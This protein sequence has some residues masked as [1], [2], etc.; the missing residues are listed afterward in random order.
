MRKTK[1]GL[2]LL[3]ALLALLL[4]LGMLPFSALASPAEITVYVSAEN[5]TYPDGAWNGSLLDSYAVTVPVGTDMMAATIQALEENDITHSGAA[6]GYISEINGL[7]EGEGSGLGGWMSVL[8]DWFMNTSA[9]LVFPEDGD[10][11]R[12]MYSLDIGEDIGGS[13]FNNDT[14]LT[15]LTFSAG[16]LTPT[17]NEDIYD[18][19]LT[20]PAGTESVK[21]V[22][23]AANKN[24]Q[25]R[26]IVGGTEY[27][28]PKDVPTADGT[29]ITVR[30]GDPSWPTMN[31][32]SPFD[33]TDYTITVAID[34]GTT[35]PITG[36]PLLTG[37]TITNISGDIGFDPE[38]FS[39]DLTTSAATTAS[40]V[41]TP[42]FSDAYGLTVSDAEYQSGDAITVSTDIGANTVTLR[43]ADKLDEASYS[44]YTFNIFR[45]RAITL[46][47]AFT[48]LP[49][50]A[51]ALANI[52]IE[53][54]AECTRL[55]ASADGVPTTSTTFS[56][57]V[58]NYYAYLLTETDCIEI[59]FGNASTAGYIRVLA[60]GDEIYAPQP[61][62]N[63]MQL[64]DIPVVGEGLTRI[65][66]Q[67]CTAA[68][69]EDNGTGFIAEAEYT[70]FINNISLPDDDFEKMMLTDMTI[71]SGEFTTPFTPD[72]YIYSPI[73]IL[74]TY[75][76]AITYTFMVNDSETK[77]FR[78][79]TSSSASNTLTPDEEGFY[80][81]SSTIS[82]AFLP[83]QILGYQVVFATERVINGL[84]V[85]VQ[86]KIMYM[87]A[88]SLA[89]FK[90]V[91]Y[92]VP[93]SQYTN[94]GLYGMRPE[95][96][97]TGS[98]IS[99]GNF[100]GYITVYFEEAIKNDPANRYG[101]DLYIA[102]N[103]EDGGAGFAEPGNVWVSEDGEQW[104]LLAGS[105]YF[106]DNTLRDYEVT[107]SRLPNGGS[108]YTDNYGSHIVMNPDPVG[109][110]SPMYKYPL[111]A[112]YS[113]YKWEPG[114]ENN[115]TFTGPLLLGSGADPFG[116]TLAG[117]PFWG[118]VDVASSADNPYT[119]RGDGFDISWAIDEDGVPVYL[120]E[121]HYVKI[122]TASHIYSGGIGEKSTE[123]GEVRRAE[124][125]GN[126]VGVTAA[127]G[128]I[129]INGKALDV[130]DG[131]YIYSA[132]AGEGE[133]TISVDAGSANVFINNQGGTSRTYDTAPTSGIIR[134]IVQ[135]GEKEP[136]I[137]YITLAGL[138]AEPGAPW[139][140]TIDTGWY[141]TTAASFTI[142]TAGQLAGL[143][144]IVNGTAFGIDQDSFSEKAIIL[145]A[146]V[147]LSG[148]IEWTPIGSASANAFAGTFEGDG[149]TISGL[150]IPG[151]AYK[152][153]FGYIGA[154]GT[155]Y[156]LTISGSTIIGTEFIGLA[157]ARNEGGISG[158]T[159]RDSSV[160]SIGTNVGIVGGIVGSN[161]GTVLACANISADVNFTQSSGTDR[162]VGGIVGDNQGGISYCF[163]N[164]HIANI[165]TS[166]S[167]GYYGGI[168]GDN[169]GEIDSCYNTGV[170]DRGWYSGGIAGRSTVPIFNAYNIGDI[171][172]GGT[173]LGAIL[174]GGTGGSAEN[175]YCLLSA[176]ENSAK[177]GIAK[178]EIELQNIASALGGAFEDDL[179]TPAPINNGYPI[180]KWQDPEVTYTVTLTVTPQNA[181]VVFTPEGGGEVI[182]PASSTGG[183]FVFSGLSQGNYLYTVSNESEDYVQSGGSVSV[184]RVDINRVISLE[185]NLYQVEFNITPLDATVF[186]MTPGFE[187]SQRA[188]SGEAGF[189]LPMGTYGYRVSK[190]GYSDATGTVTVAKGSGVAAPVTAALEESAKQTVTFVVTPVGAVVTV[191]HPEDGVQTAGLDGTYELYETT[192]DYTVKL[193]GYI[194]EKG[195]FAVLSSGDNTVYVD[196]TAGTPV[197]NGGVAYGFYGGSGTEDDPYLIAEAEELAYM[198]SLFSDP[199]VYPDYSN[200]NY[201]L[202][203]EI[204]L[205]GAIEWA[206][207]GSSS[208]NGFAGIFDGHGHTINGLY[209]P[210]GTYK[211]L[212][213][214]V[215]AEG[216]VRNLTVSGSSVTGIEYVGLIA[217]S[218]AGIVSGITAEDSIVS[219][220][221]ANVGMIGGIVGENSGTIIAC[222][223]ISARVNYTQS[224]GTD[225]GVGGI[226]GG[227]S[228]EISLSINNARIANIGT[229]TSYGYY[230]GITGD[231]AGLIDSCYNTGVIDRG[232]NIGG[233]AGRSSYQ[234]LNSY[235]IGDIETG[236]T[237]G[238]I[239]AS[240][241]GGSGAT[242]VNCYCLDS[243]TTSSTNGTAKTETEIKGLAPELGGAFES[244]MTPNINNGYPIL[245]WQNPDTTYTVT[246]TVTP[247]D[248]EVVFKAAGDSTAL[249]P[250][251][252]EYGVYIFSG[253]SEGSYQY[254]VSND[255]GDYMAASGSISVSRADVSQAISLAKTLY[256]IQFNVT[257]AGTSVTV[258]ANGF[259]EKKTSDGT[260]PVVFSLPMGDYSYTAQK[261]G[262]SDVQ[263]SISVVKGSGV[264]APVTIAL[265]QSAQH[266]ITFAVTPG[267]A[268][269]SVI[270]PD[271]GIQTPEADG[272]YLLYETNYSYIVKLSGYITRKGTV[273][274]TG[275]ETIEIALTEGTP[276][277]DGAIA[278]SFYGGSGTELDPYL[279]ADGEELALLSGLI[280]DTATNPEYSTAYYKVVAH[281]DLGGNA[282]NFS[283]IGSNN[284]DDL[285]FEGSFDG[286]G[287]IISNLYV[288]KT[289]QAV[290]FFGFA[291]NYTGS[292][293]APT[294]G[295][296]KNVVL[297]DPVIES[298]ALYTGG[299][300]GWCVGQ[301]GN[302]YPITNCAVINGKVTSTS[303]Y[304]GGLVGSAS[305]PAI[306]ECYAIAEISGGTSGG[307][308]GVLAGAVVTSASIGYSFARGK[309]S[310]NAYV[311]GFIGSTIPSTLSIRYSYVD[312]EVVCTGTGT[313]ATYGLVSAASIPA[314]SVTN[315]Y[316]NQ[317]ASCTSSSTGAAVTSH[318]FTG[319]TAVDLK[320]EDTLVTLNA[321]GVKYALATQ[322]QYAND[323]YPYLIDTFTI[324]NDLEQLAAPTN[325][326]WS[327]FGVAEWDAVTNALGYKITL[328][329]SGAMVVTL[330]TDGSTHSL[331]LSGE[332]SMNGSGEYTFTVTAIG[333]GY[334][335]YN[336]PE[337]IL[338][339][340]YTATI[341]V[342]YVTFNISLPDGE[343]FYRPGDPVITV[344]VGTA[345]VSFVNGTAQTLPEGTGYLYE[346]RALGFSTI[347][348]TLNV[349]SSPV[350]VTET[351]A[352]DAGWDGVTTMEPALVDG[353]RLISSGY[354]L[355]WFRDE[356]NK[357]G[358]GYALNAKVVRDIDLAG[359]EWAP[360]STFTSSSATVGYTGT[361]DGNGYTISGL[362]ITT[363]ANGSGL[364][365]YV[366][367]GGLI[368]NVTVDGDTTGGQYSGGVAGCISAATISNCNN[369]A[370]VTYEK[371]TN[372]GIFVGGIVG[373]MSNYTYV[374]SLVE[375]C[376]NHGTITATTGTNNY[377]GGVVG[378]AS[379][380]VAIRYCG[381]E[382][383]VNGYTSIGGITGD[384]SIPIISCYNTGDVTGSSERVGGIAGFSNKLTQ[385]CYNIGAV[386]GQSQVGGIV[387]NLNNYSSPSGFVE[388]CY[389]VGSVTATGGIAATCGSI[390]GEKYQAGVVVANSF[391]LTGTAASGIGNNIHVDDSAVEMTET[392]LKQ[393]STVAWLGSAFAHV[394]GG[395]P[396]LRRQ[397]ASTD[398]AILFV[399][400]PS[401]A[402][403]VV[404]D[405]DD[406]IVYPAE[407]GYCYLLPTG[408]YKYEASKDDYIPVSGSITIPSVNT[409]VS[410]TMFPMTD[411]DLDITAAKAVI[412]SALSGVTFAQQDVNDIVG[413]KA[414]V[415]TI[416]AE[417]DLNGVTAIVADVAF[418]SAVAGTASN[419]GG[420]DGSYEF[421]VALTKGTG[422]EQIYSGSPTIAATPYAPVG[423]VT[424]DIYYGNANKSGFPVILPGYSLDPGL[425]EAFGFTDAYDGEQATMLDAV[426][427]AHIAVYGENFAALDVLRVPSGGMT[428]MFGD[429][430]GNYMF[431]VNDWIP[432]DGSDMYSVPQMTLNEGDDV[433]LFVGVEDWLGWDSYVW[434]ESGGSKAGEISVTTDEAVVLTLMGYDNYYWGMM[435]DYPDNV[436]IPFKD[437][438]IVDMLVSDNDA[439]LSAAFNGAAV[440][441][442]TNNSGV[443]TVT[444]DTPGVYYLS[445][446][447][448]DIEDDVPILP[449]WIVVTVTDSGTPPPLTD[450]TALNGKI[451]EAQSK[452]A[453]AQV[454][455]V[456]GQYPQSAVNALTSAISAAQ[457][458]ANSAGATQGQINSA[459][460]TLTNAISAFDALKVPEPTEPPE[461]P[462]PA[463]YQ[464]AMNSAL[465]YILLQ[466]SDP[467]VSSVG[468]EW[469]VLARARAGKDDQAWNSLYLANLRAAITGAYSTADNKVILR[470][471]QP[472]ENERVILALTA[473]GYD[474]SDF[475]GYDFVTPL[476]DMTWVQWQGV[477]SLAFA[478][479]ALNSKPYYGIDITPLLTA[480]LDVQHGDGGWGLTATSTVDMTAMTIQALAPYYGKDAA[481]TAAV[482]NALT[483]LNGRTI[484]DAEG[485]AQVIVAIA[486]LGLNAE[487]YVDALLTFYDETSGGF[488]R[489]GFVDLMSTEQA[490]YALVAYDRYLNGKSA[491]YDMSDLGTPPP[492]P[493]VDDVDAV[494]NTATALTWSIIGVGNTAPDD[495]RS[496]LNLPTIGEDG[497]TIAWSS[498]NTAYI[499][500]TGVVTRPGYAEGNKTVTL[501]ATVTKGS[502]VS[503]VTFTL[504]VEAQNAPSGIITYA[505]ISVID[506]GA[507]GNQT[508]VYFDEEQLI[509]NDGET[510]FSLLLRTGLDIRTATYSQYTGV[511]VEAINGFG[512]FDDGPLSGWMYKVNG[513]FPDYSASLYTLKNGDVV[514]WIYTRNLG[515]D[516]GGGNYV[517]GTNTSGSGSGEDGADAAEIGEAETPL[518]QLV[519]TNQF[520][521][522]KAGAWY[523]EAVKY[524]YENGLM[525]GVSDILFAPNS[526]ITAAMLVT[527]LARSAGINTDGG[528]TWYEK[529]VTWGMEKDITDGTNMGED[530]SRQRFVTILY[531]YAEMLGYDTS[532]RADLSGFDDMDE[533]AEWAKDAME[534]AVAEGL[535]IGRAPT[536]LAPVGTTTRAEAAMLLMRF[537][538]MV[539]RSVTT[540]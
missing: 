461:P 65:S 403:I 502:A 380:G 70:L 182:Q 194:T 49:G 409:V 417:L 118:Y 327:G 435:M 240:V 46:S 94:T 229:S 467:I 120:E 313:T 84:T 309:V 126:E 207:I 129:S 292:S 310:G 85:R 501:T 158:V 137:Y 404:M 67:L 485:N 79:P 287:F 355:A 256:N 475:E 106:D 328:Y 326:V 496:N 147:D 83:E 324:V 56:A 39:Y 358:T 178:T 489:T 275:D 286:G 285:R 114:E 503:T 62:E 132:D 282:N 269:I 436:A 368:K 539:K 13:W 175:C 447:V 150:Y 430:S 105:D 394:T 20:L 15:A 171:S 128:S 536:T 254:S 218:N 226:A 187:Q 162:G 335:Y 276:V 471:N 427:A 386:T 40:V 34:S 270:H 143:A 110:A 383:V 163:N 104:Y 127:P 408:S 348:G 508:R 453:G 460:T 457:A 498:D 4:A 116:S 325:I 122:S 415:E 31:D 343:S 231:N 288:N 478:V 26:S 133:L 474:A 6:F 96:L 131:N 482:D 298:S 513:V 86:Y 43:L 140:G 51:V 91:D 322:S 209:I 138:P 156:D 211:G 483:W 176:F 376:I 159:V 124:S 420:T 342:Q 42:E 413:A 459:V 59:T 255:D 371:E 154:T 136:V 242:A 434:F 281:I 45:P 312:V 377:V 112:N 135:E 265:E 321:D 89:E 103:S 359:F 284:A 33:A 414:A 519:W 443:V 530:I 198:S 494:N 412:V 186:I 347:K 329:E 308:R 142:S 349:G 166:T 520:I 196:L 357:G 422:T 454:G 293:S 391:Y 374:E 14:Y 28:R 279:I 22:P 416:I 379:Y 360:I 202:I 534:W 294:E 428:R 353:W 495:V 248:A 458:V 101:I 301:N 537:G 63:G 449:A 345:T 500:N 441:E 400:D 451:A 384:G 109:A 366:Y 53:G 262:Y 340:A 273:T 121:I 180:L 406:Q 306:N 214:Y 247:Q 76:D 93:A 64:T 396:L 389:N 466:A 518:A 77:V 487:S 480:L 538:E 514:E 470:N 363:G 151:G 212:F 382:G 48:V 203:A 523:F 58:Y 455:S 222:A 232:W 235:N 185:R 439:Y 440:L 75:G 469:A 44:E 251:F 450:K 387:G 82:Q 38:R 532:K 72:S 289:T 437:V 141:N 410:I 381:N 445:C 527:I 47:S 264:D 423:A 304:A 161:G 521:D 123:V 97:E 426:I 204:D 183:V 113:L 344:A 477:N 257:P 367:R 378:S 535:V 300:V 174:G 263:G 506:E 17:F 295:E 540:V 258:A 108:T 213:G 522:I 149:Y 334:E 492:T 452:L 346:I 29:V 36:E 507:T 27:M 330:D 148:E 201:K 490:A 356:V 401:D 130:S 526:N 516:V 1:I 145:N 95:R 468:G 228:G 206:P 30:C 16:V 200:A 157:A 331:D 18:Y 160:S 302:P 19:V 372:L 316:F 525:R 268:K 245:K 397:S 253:L 237:R 267:G 221:G 354:E 233:I 432:G 364:F 419:Q 90:V 393:L 510:A 499:S 351:M 399:A 139:D 23:T 87:D 488:K 246:L 280:S 74:G 365:G 234:I 184:S 493:P 71:S 533:V 208:E 278:N 61:Y 57:T 481:I 323:G 37:I 102:G 21:V 81:F 272:T 465:T 531:R 210:S 119:K 476:A 99:L 217:G 395:Y 197:W 115:M 484:T 224:S 66:L 191:S 107:Y 479:I 299:L 155:V 505:K 241:V 431:F 392:E 11:I 259:A 227:N 195:S 462:T 167:Y 320:S 225:R 190:L 117:F 165:G 7:A 398:Y 339:A 456:P 80:T 341:S 69:Y 55:Q 32:D 238:A 352:P 181:E 125:A 315:S 152:G 370:D 411:D 529:A 402:A 170:I 504:T 464:T 230:G 305:Y 252:S 283:P 491:I 239:F 173:N 303:N 307:Y 68:T 189:M 199:A 25:V 369:Y 337:S 277:W 418:T 134:V 88:D 314:A 2:R 515:D 390:V 473:L 92:I 424:V 41:I 446:M 291:R 448:E 297:L 215:A 193:A 421:T 444:F 407:S 54:R 317:D 290:G 486:S 9:N 220:L 60:D 517:T 472:T 497:V 375:Y 5:T 509:L 12:W 52:L 3:A 361:F 438:Y 511:Y 50:T 205:G 98:L 192:Y 100:G 512:E 271:D 73:L 10:D 8:N 168:A 442:K 179:T 338:S 425:S 463:T 169:S 244:D 223:N 24:F 362:S 261:F 266:T 243:F 35:Q 311:G 249:T 111:K 78:S 219:S 188:D 260:D 177:N 373:Y 429:S 524:A 319:K 433:R 250:D 164:A 388:N 296:L 172:V 274:V 153:L 144:A 216:T 332:I 333:D 236:G 528:A 146:D 318:N 336:S 350:T 405:S 385:D